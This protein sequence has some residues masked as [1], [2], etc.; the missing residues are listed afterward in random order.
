[1]IDVLFSFIHNKLLLYNIAFQAWSDLLRIILFFFTIIFRYSIHSGDSTRTDDLR[2]DERFPSVRLDEVAPKD[3]ALLRLFV[4]DV[5]RVRW[6]RVDREVP[7][8]VLPLLSTLASYPWSSAFTWNH[9]G[10]PL[11]AFSLSSIFDKG[12]RGVTLIFT[13]SLGAP[14][15]TVERLP[16]VVLDDI[17]GLPSSR[18]RSIVV[19]DG[20]IQRIAD[21]RRAA[22]SFIWTLFGT[23]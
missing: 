2:Y 19:L 10:V 7:I 20:R 6:C 3:P 15:I 11:K 22:K 9:S 5:D 18:S 16:P 21:S 17:V 23:R 14:P 1:M 4:V 12:R 13:G 8:E